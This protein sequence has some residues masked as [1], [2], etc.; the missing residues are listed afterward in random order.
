M[1]ALRRH[2]DYFLKKKRR[3]YQNGYCGTTE[4]LTGIYLN[5]ATPC[6]C[7]ICGND[8][9]YLNKKS[10]KEISGIELMKLDIRQLN[11]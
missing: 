3:S 4:R 2:N 10:I 6:S 11:D 5:T 9:K 1:R 7:P 8:R